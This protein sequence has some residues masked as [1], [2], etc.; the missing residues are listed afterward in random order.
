MSRNGR[1]VFVS[2]D[3]VAD[4]FGRIY[5]PVARGRTDIAARLMPH[6]GPMAV[7]AYPITFW[8]RV[9]ARIPSGVGMKTITNAIEVQV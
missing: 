5:T 9:A 4:N 7:H 6:M 3:Y 1:A 8:N 2:Q